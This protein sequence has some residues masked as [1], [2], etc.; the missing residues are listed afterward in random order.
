MRLFTGRGVALLLTGAALTA[1]GLA[2]AQRDLL[3]LGILLLVIPLL[4]AVLLRFAPSSVRVRRQV[5]PEQLAP[6]STATVR[7]QLLNPSRTWTRVLLASDE[8]P[9]MFGHAPR[10]AVDRLAPGTDV[11][12][13]YRLTCAARGSYAIGPLH[14]RVGD[15]L[16]MAERRW[17]DLGTDQLIVLP[18]VHPLTDSTGAGSAQGQLDSGEAHLAT[19][20]DVDVSTREY[21]PGDDLRRV[22][23]RATARHGDLMVRREEQSQ[24]RLATVLV[25]ARHVG[26]TAPG[27][28]GDT[29][30]DAGT[31]S[32]LEWAISAAASICEHLAG[33]GFAV[34]LVTDGVDHGWVAADDR[35]GQQRQLVRLALLQPTPAHTLAEAIEVAASG[36]AGGLAIAV[37]GAADAAT[38][39]AL[40]RVPPGLA[41]LLAAPE[42]ARQR[43]GHTGTGPAEEAELRRIGW[44]CAAYRPGDEVSDVW[45]EL[46]SARAAR[47]TT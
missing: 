20:V 3:R 18:R 41:V 44:A 38:A 47:A 4:S 10:F 22:H 1:A 11:T 37:L 39:T 17:S 12:V 27:H 16:G 43:L 45:R 28:A 36:A 23:W 19:S 8:V 6:G 26:H 30:A 24:E 32:S 40:S 5:Q 35:S 2:V 14:Y 34:R 9:D 33:Q 7:V 46:L 21:R 42:A 29:A 13:T 31:A 25:D 15:A